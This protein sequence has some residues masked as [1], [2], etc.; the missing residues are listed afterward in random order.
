[1]YPDEP[2]T[3]LEP[4]EDPLLVVGCRTEGLKLLAPKPLTFVCL[5]TCFNVIGMYVE[6]PRNKDVE[7]C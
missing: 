2:D 7:C 5:F 6:V 3:Y 4:L 1:M